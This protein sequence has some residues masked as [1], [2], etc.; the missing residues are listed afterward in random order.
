MEEGPEVAEEENQEAKLCLLKEVG[1]VDRELNPVLE[2][3]P[4]LEQEADLEQ[5]HVQD[6]EILSVAVDIPGE[7]RG[8]GVELDSEEK[9]LIPTRHL[10]DKSLS[11]LQKG[12][13]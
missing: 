6:R 2:Q 9:V 5:E 4:D 12:G 1:E 3:E 7:G 11:C 10:Q 13:F 8:Q